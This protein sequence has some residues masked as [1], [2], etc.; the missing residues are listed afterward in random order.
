MQSG[1][2]TPVI[3]RAEGRYL[4]DTDGQSYFDLAS[5]LVAV[6]LGHS[7]PAVVKAI[8]EQ[9]ATLCYAAPS[10]MVDKR[11]QLAHALSQLSPWHRSSEGCRVFFTTTGAES[12]DDA[13]R[14]ARSITGRFKVLGAYRSFHGSTGT[15]ITL[16]GED[17]RFGA[18]PG[19]PGIARFFAPFPYRSP[20]WAN[21]P[22]QE[23]ERAIA[24]LERTLVHEDPKRVA[25]IIIEPVV[26]SN[27]VIVYPPGYLNALRE[28][29][30]KHGILLIFDEVM[31]G[32]GRTGAA[33]AANRFNVTPDII[34]FAKGVTSAYIPLGG[35]MVR[36]S[37]ARTFDTRP[38]PCGHTYSGHPLCM[39]TA[40]AVLEAYAAE[41]L[42]HRATELEQWLSEGLSAIA[43]RHANVG[44]VRG[45][46]AF[47]VIELVKDRT[48]KEPIVPWH[49]EG[50]GIMK[51]FYAEMR[52]RGVITFG[53]YNCVMVSPP[54]TTEKSELSR[55]L[56]AVDE[57]LSAFE[58]TL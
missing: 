30:S 44:D 29:T 28:L 13:V 43:S 5:G 17:R 21:S 52:K 7:H 26:G 38:L 35:V 14:I 33:F 25:A 31:T 42:F 9:A 34:T 23:T 48:S 18:E 53:R 37:L 1:F 16:T 54:L 36:E 40:L 51:T 4:Y 24:H 8:A 50:L 57:A 19:A 2:A 11:A 32:F 47:F 15:A 39:A 58:S 46:G 49:G 41:N 3:A 22:E 56:V 6:N 12:N 27:G 20:F 45:V 55:A 10:M